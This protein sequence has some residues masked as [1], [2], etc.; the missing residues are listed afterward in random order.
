MINIHFLLSHWHQNVNTANC[1]L[2]N[3]II[4]QFCSNM[5]FI[6]RCMQM[7]KFVSQMGFIKLQ[8]SQKLNKALICVLLSIYQHTN[9]PTTKK[10]KQAKKT[11]IHMRMSV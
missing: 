1:G 6:P 4:N 10:N 8:Q 7:F 2:L 5:L 9:L 3:A 11:Q